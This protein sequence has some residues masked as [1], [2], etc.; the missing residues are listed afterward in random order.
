M[1]LSRKER[2]AAACGRLIT[3][4]VGVDRVVRRAEVAPRVRGGDEGRDLVGLLREDDREAGLEVEV[5]VAVEEP[6]AGVV[7]PEADRDVVARGGRARVHDV[8]EDRVVVVV[9]GAARAADDG[10]D[11]LRVMGG[12]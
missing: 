6:R 7:R 10:E 2:V 11:V 12:E 5:D 9:L 1:M 4:A 3:I 8:A